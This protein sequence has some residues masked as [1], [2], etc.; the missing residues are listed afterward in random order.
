MPA[1]VE[2]I[3]ELLSSVAKLSEVA[4]R[5]QLTFAAHLLDMLQLELTMVMFGRSEVDD[6]ATLAE[7]KPDK[8]TNRSRTAKGGSARLRR[9]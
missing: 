2:E 7:T 4:S 1:R 6:E 8:P 9:A 5:N 3:N